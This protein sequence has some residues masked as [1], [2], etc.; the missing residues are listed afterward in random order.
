[1]IALNQN[2]IVALGDHGVVPNGLHAFFL[3]CYG[4]GDYRRRVAKPELT[5]KYESI[6]LSN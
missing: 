1:V 6:I 2:G 3:G 5:V 4:F